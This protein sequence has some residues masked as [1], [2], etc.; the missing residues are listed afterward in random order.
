[1]HDKPFRWFA[2]DLFK[3]RARVMRRRS[4]PAYSSQAG[5][6]GFCGQATLED[7]ISD[8]SGQAGLGT[9]GNT[10]YGS[11][12]AQVSRC[13]QRRWRVAADCGLLLLGTGEVTI[14][15]SVKRHRMSKDPVT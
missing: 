12:S 8:C 13:C 9:G 5:G 6:P 7:V 3:V 14:R 11:G 15:I 4:R 10:D 2:E 1:M